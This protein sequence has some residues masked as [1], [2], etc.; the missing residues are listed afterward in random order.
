MTNQGKLRKRRGM[1]FHLR[2]LLVRVKSTNLPHVIYCLITI[3]KY[4][5]RIFIELQPVFEN[6]S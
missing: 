5:L 3:S 4:Y 1:C 2:T 6:S